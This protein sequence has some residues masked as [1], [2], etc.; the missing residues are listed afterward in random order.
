MQDLPARDAEHARDVLAGELV[1]APGDDLVEQ[2]HRVAHAARGLARDDRER[3]VVTRDL[4]LLEHVAQAR[5]DRS[6]SGIS[7]KS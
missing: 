7:L 1:A 4:L 6:A 3:R 2:A 5:G